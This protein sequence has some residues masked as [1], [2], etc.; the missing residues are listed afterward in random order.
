GEDRCAGRRGT[1]GT[2][3]REYV[4]EPLLRFRSGIRV[5]E[6][7]LPA[8]L[9]PHTTGAREHGGEAIALGELPVDRVQDDDVLRPGGFERM[10]AG[11]IGGIDAVPTRRRHVDNE[12]VG[13]TGELD[14]LA[15]DLGA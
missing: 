11:P 2:A 15:E 9:E 14:E 6:V 1:D 5:H 13:T 12:S 3:A 4:V 10:R 7:P 8:S